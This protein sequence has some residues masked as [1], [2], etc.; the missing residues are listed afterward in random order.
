MPKLLRANTIRFLEGS[1]HCL[2]LALSALAYKTWAKTRAEHVECVPVVGLLGT[3]AE[4]GMSACLVQVGGEGALRVDASRYKTGRQILTEFRRLV[5]ERVPASAFLV[6]GVDDAPAHR[7]ALEDATAGFTPLVA[8]RAAALHGAFGLGR[9]VCLELAAAVAAFLKVLR[10]SSKMRPYLDVVPEPPPYRP[11]RAVLLDELVRRVDGGQAGRD[12]VL[13]VYLLLPEVTEEAPE[14]LGAF[15]RVSVTPNNNDIDLLVRHLGRALPVALQRVRGG[16]NAQPVVVA[17][18]A[19][20]AIPIAPH[21][22]RA[23]LVDI[24]DQWYAASAL[25]NGRLEQGSLSLPGRDLVLD[26]FRVVVAGGL[27]DAQDRTAHRMWPLALAAVKDPG[28]AAPYWFLLRNCD[29]LGQL[30]ALVGRSAR[31][32]SGAQRRRAQ[33]LVAGLTAMREGRALGAD[34]PL[35][36]RMDEAETAADDKRDGLAS[37]IGG[38]RD[39]E[40]EENKRLIR[41]VATFSRP[42]GD[43][44]EKL[45]DGELTLPPDDEK[46][47]AR[48]LA[49]AASDADDVDALVRLLREPRFVVAHTAA[50]KALELIDFSRFGPGTEPGEV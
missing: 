25:A 17:P 10:Q 18:N 45:L 49:E 44:I 30:E 12:D 35:V 14:W 7:Q 47:W 9:D 16:A 2:D 3:A 42:V 50:R 24:R 6:Q 36:R 19:P 31:L 28:T 23:A 48:L 4:L 26:V 39:P 1:C 11:E 5:R 32:G 33:D 41:E 29:D 20:G 15:E 13:A 34:H 40:D 22:L 37:R 46:Y 27:D 38:G 21:R 43:A 8:A